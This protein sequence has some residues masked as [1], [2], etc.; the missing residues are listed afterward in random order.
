MMKR[1]RIWM[2]SVG[3][4]FFMGV[5]GILLS[6]FVFS[7]L[8]GNFLLLVG[9]EIYNRYS[10]ALISNPMIY[11]AEVGLLFLFLV[12]LILGI[13]LTREN[14]MARPIGYE[15]QPKGNKATDPTSKM[16]IFHGMIILAFLVFHILTFKYGTYYEVTY[17]EVVMRDLARLVR[18]SFQQPLYVGIYAFAVML[19][20][21]HLS[22]GLASAFQ[23]LGIRDTRIS[24]K[25]KLAS[26]V[27]GFVVAAG[28]VSQ[29]IYMF[30]W[31]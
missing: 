18:E 13:S 12:H 8:A 25:L 29:P 30:F 7:H 28:F 14:R 16:M 6:L 4:K 2:S 31:S 23:S 10:H 9:D 20:G 11:V 1:E 3:R 26:Q 15:V 17:G 22:Y 19:L 24:C 5:T 21:L 27:V